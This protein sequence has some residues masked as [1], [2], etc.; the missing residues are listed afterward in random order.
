MDYLS[1]DICLLVKSAIFLTAIKTLDKSKGGNPVRQ[2]FLPQ[3]IRD[4]DQ[5]LHYLS[6]ESARLGEFL[7]AAFGRSN[8]R[9]HPR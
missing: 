9:V 5:V 1:A 8:G 4:E 7:T 2:S 3:E 6:P